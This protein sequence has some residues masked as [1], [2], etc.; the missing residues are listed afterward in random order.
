MLSAKF[1]SHWEQYYDMGRYPLDFYLYH[2]SRARAAKK[3]KRLRENLIALLHWKDG[4]AC[5]Y[6][7]D[8]IHAKTLMLKP[9]VDLS[10]SETTDLHEA[11]SALANSNGGDVAARTDRLRKNLENMWHSVE[12]PAFFL[13]IALP[14]R[15]PIIDPHTVRGYLAI[16]GDRIVDRPAIDWHLWDDY[17]KFYANTCRVIGNAQ[18]IKQPGKIDRALSAFGK[19]LKRHDDL[20]SNE[21]SSS[22]SQ[23]TVPVFWGQWVNAQ[24]V[25]PS[26]CHVVKALERYLAKGGIDYLPQWEKSNIR[27]LLLHRVKRN[28]LLGLLLNPGGKVARQLITYYREKM[29]GKSNIK[30]LPRP[31]LDVFLVG[32]SCRCGMKGKM[33]MTKHLLANGYGD[34]QNAAMAIITVGQTTGSLFGLLDGLGAPTELFSRYYSS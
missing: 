8:E 11:F 34:T 31:I 19:A 12:V 22:P 6:V 28:D 10:K 25:V 13:H 20:F 15:F 7:P 5:A 29:Q 32:W 4:K 21:K 24:R 14:N 33:N 27:G 23:Q 1:V 9:L 26:S 16:T 2:G 17:V 30:N 3:P 18:H